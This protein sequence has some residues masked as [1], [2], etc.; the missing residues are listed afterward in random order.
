[1]LSLVSF[2]LL[3]LRCHI[4]HRSPKRLQR[5]DARLASEAKVCNFQVE[6]LIDENVFQLN[7]S[8]HHF[9]VVY[10]FKCVEELGEEKSASI[11]AH[12][13]H[14]LAKIKEAITWNVLHC[15]VLK[16]ADMST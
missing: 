10:V 3:N 8:V 9:F 2:A 15:D 12:R 4:L 6:L 5:V 16:V 13:F 11:F 1:M 14:C 7:I